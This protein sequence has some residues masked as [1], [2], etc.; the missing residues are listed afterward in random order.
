MEDLTTTANSIADIINELFGNIFSSIDNSIYE[1]LDKI[2]FIDSSII[3]NTSFS[4]LFGDKS[5]EGILLICNAL[6]LGIIIF[7][8]TNYL[9]SH[10]TYSKIQTPSQF[11]FKCVI[12]IGIMNESLWI[13]S[14]IINIISLI[15]SSIQYIG[16]Q[17][18]G[19]E[20]SFMNFIKKINDT[21]YTSSFILSITS[22]EGIIKS[23][24]SIGFITLIFS[25][26]LR[27]IMIQIFVL[28]SPFVF[29]C[30][31]NDRT[32]WI[33]KS[34]IKAFIS[35]LLE[36][37]L[38]ALILLLAFS[39][40]F[41]SNDTLSQIIYIG[42]IYALM[43]ANTYMYMLFGGITTSITNNFSMFNRNITN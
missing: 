5:T 8:A 27:Y 20:I 36:Q 10:L 23:V 25:Y 28:L 12:F 37:V 6:I 38:I 33:F 7:Y 34:W 24:T 40:E 3:D 43:K 11:I 4:K 31:I 13:C 16:E 22:F 17:I 39:M 19:E 26:A 32:E 14:Q 35:L 21:I 15:S 30:L 29:L 2:T 9:F 42:I 18:L 41:T 1:L